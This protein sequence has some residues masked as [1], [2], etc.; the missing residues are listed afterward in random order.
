MMCG[1]YWPING[2]IQIIIKKQPRETDDADIEKDK[3]D[4][5]L[6]NLKVTR[7]NDER[8]IIMKKACRNCGRVKAIQSD[9]LCGGCNGAVYRKHTKGTPEYNDALAEAKKRFNDPNYHRG[10]K[11]PLRNPTAT[12]Q[13]IKTHARALGIKHNGGDPE[14]AGVIATLQLERERCLLR[15]EKLTQA[16]EILQS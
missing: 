5:R 6:C 16:I 13:K 1:N 7:G 15:A 2:A 3:M 12:V 11:R 14:N 8:E 9:G 10:G 4:S